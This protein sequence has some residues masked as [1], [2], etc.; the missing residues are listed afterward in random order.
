M[1]K[2]LITQVEST[3]VN[4]ESE[5]NEIAKYDEVLFKKESLFA[6]QQLTKNPKSDYALKVAKGNP[7]SLKFAIMNVASIGISLS[8]A[9][10]QAY[11]VPRDNQIVLDISYMGLCHLAQRAGAVKWVQAKVTRKNDHFMLRDIGLPPVHEYDPRGNRG[12]IDGVYCV[13]FTG[14]SHLVDFMTIEEV[15]AIRDRSE[16]YKNERSRP[17]SPW[18]TAAEEMIKKTVVKRASKMWPVTE[19]KGL[20]QAVEVLNQHQGIDFHEERREAELEA[21]GPLASS[22]TIEEITTLI[23]K[24]GRTEKQFLDF[25]KKM[26]RSD[27]T[28]ENIRS[29]EAEKAIKELNSILENIITKQQKE[30]PEAVNDNSHAD[31]IIDDMCNASF[32]ADDI[33]F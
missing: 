17:Y 28:L 30:E 23:E 13:A 33:E 32:T 21:L 29:K 7:T 4:F 24:L 27:L 22:D 3:I 10:K 1:S 26:T 5:F 2:E 19:D 12:E 20:Y 14:T 16:G 25:F 8:P 11:L 31:D 15:F 6:V 9:T 18:V